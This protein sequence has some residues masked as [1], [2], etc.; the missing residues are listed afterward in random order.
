MVEQGAAGGSG[1]DS[2]TMAISHR[3]GTTAILDVVRERQPPFSPEAVIKE[4]A[5]VF[6]QYRPARLQAIGMEPTFRSSSSPRKASS[7]SAASGRSQRFMPTPSRLQL[8][9]GRP[10]G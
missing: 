4:F 1:G 8:A 2:F 9:R 10:A 5:A 7:C 6:R 3:G